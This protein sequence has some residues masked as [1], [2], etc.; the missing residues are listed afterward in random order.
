[1]EF[2]KLASSIFILLAMS[3]LLVAAF[4]ARQRELFLRPCSYVIHDIRFS[5]ALNAKKEEF[6]DSIFG[7]FEEGNISVS[8]NG[9]QKQFALYFRIYNI[10]KDGQS[11]KAPLVVVHGG[12]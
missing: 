10:Q 7:R 8:R 12:P 11:S 5:N 1:M 4:S 3:P 9:G 2:M 6:D